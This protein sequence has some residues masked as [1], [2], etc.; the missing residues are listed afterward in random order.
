MKAFRADLHLHT[1]LSPCGD[2]EMS[3]SRLVEQAH[4][5]GLNII[6]IT[7]HNST[8]HA[9]LVEKLA[10]EK[11]IFTLCGAEVTSKEEVHLLCFMPDKKSLRK[12]Q[13]YIDKHLQ[14]IPNKPDYFGEQLLVNE[15]EEI[16]NEEP[17]LLINALDQDVDEISA[18]VYEQEGIFIPAHIDRAA[19]SLTSQLGFVPPDLKC[20]AYEISKHTTVEKMIDTAPYLQN[21]CYIESCDGH[22]IADVATVFS[23]M[24]MEELT[25]EEIKKALAGID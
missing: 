2:L 9:H 6:G 3:P 16:L 8:K 12:L 25:F 5:M 19:F 15:K 21:S 4:L 24:H 17:Y 22:Y 10:R 7:D 11:G 18:F 20:H 14:K 1:V 13:D 23:V